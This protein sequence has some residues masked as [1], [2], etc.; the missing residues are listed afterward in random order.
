[1]FELNPRWQDWAFALTKDMALPDDAL[2]AAERAKFA[3]Y[4]NA[5][6]PPFA[7]KVRPGGDD[8]R[9]GAKLTQWANAWTKFWTRGKGE[10]V[11]SAM[12]ETGT[13][14]S[15][16][17]LTKVGRADRDRVMVLR[18]ASN[19]TMPPKGADPAGYLLRENQG[20]AGMTA[21]LE[22]LDSVGGKVVERDRDPLGPL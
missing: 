20:Y 7:L 17:Y 13:F 18:A 9:H 19:F 6:K 16:E 10:F 4:P 21:A 14:Q 12:E 11:T 1:M 8:L 15:I 2:I 5:Q 3:G 22:S